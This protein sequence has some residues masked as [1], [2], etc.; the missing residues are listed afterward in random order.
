MWWVK[1]LFERW[2]DTRMPSNEERRLQ[3]LAAEA[4]E[5]RERLL[6]D[7]DKFNAAFTDW[8][9]RSADHV[10]VWLEQTAVDYEVSHQMS[11]ESL[12]QARWRFAHAERRS[13]RWAPALRGYR[14]T[15]SI[16]GTAAAA[17]FT[18][19]V[20]AYFRPI[21]PLPLFA[22][23]IGESRKVFLPDGSTMQLNTRSRARVRYTANARIIELDEG[24]AL[25]TVISDPNKPFD[26]RAGTF[27]VRVLG[28]V[29]SVRRDGAN[30]DTLVAEGRVQV[31][32]ASSILGSLLPSHAVGAPLSPG[33]RLVLDTQPR[34]QQ[35]P[36]K[37][38]ER[39][40]Q[41]TRGRIQFEEEPLGE[42]VRE[43]NRY[44]IHDVE[45]R[46][47][48]LRTVAVGGAYRINNADA[49][50]RELERYFGSAR[51]VRH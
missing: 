29:F 47:P 42:V 44:T 20:W 46:D 19:G 50:A 49:Y 9:L 48:A 30:V 33:N 36:P 4:V 26:V 2:T 51:V 11:A 34:R 40:L 17:I 7:E 12:A 39:R 38:V 24:E 21:S 32:E 45:I 28:T 25:F 14:T 6:T 5:W 43:L 27:S 31:L 15:A 10:K 8:L 22:T 3:R 1:R 41:W 35:L 18:L 13:H 16:A 37:G 23:G